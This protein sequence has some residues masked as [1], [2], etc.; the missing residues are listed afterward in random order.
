M[1][2]PRTTS[3][4]VLA[5]AALCAVAVAVALLV[6]HRMLQ[7]SGAALAETVQVF[8]DDRAQE[9]ARFAIARTLSETEAEREAVSAYVLHGDADTVRFLSEIDA[10]ADRVGV[11]LVTEKLEVREAGKESA[12]A[13]LAITFGIE[14]SEA[15]VIR[16]LSLLETLPYHSSVTEADLVRR[17]ADATAGPSVASTVVLAVTFVE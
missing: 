4:Y 8:A 12:F 3:V 10:L 14:G 17:P 6:V 1:H 11:A 7:Q 2:I 16:M 9:Q 15:R 13:V 5:V